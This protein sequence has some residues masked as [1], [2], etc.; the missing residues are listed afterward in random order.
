MKNLRERIGFV[1]IVYVILYTGSYLLIM[2]EI[3]QDIYYLIYLILLYFGGIVDTFIRPIETEKKEE[4]NFEKFIGLLFILNPFIMMGSVW[5]VNLYGW[6]MESIAILGLII[7]TIGVIMLLVSR[8]T[9]GKQATGILVIRE[10]HE[11]ITT[12]IYKYIRHPIYGAGLIGV[13]GF[14]LVVQAIFIPFITVVLYFKVFND[15]AKYE[16]QMLIGEFGSDYEEYMAKS[17]RFIPFIF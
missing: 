10:D 16:E 1:L 5:E 17:K 9:L 4:G 7:Y 13:I 12:G 11:L 3:F 2:P 6:R 8:R 14:V 15:R